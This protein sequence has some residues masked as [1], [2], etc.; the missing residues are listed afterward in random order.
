MQNQPS[1]H[2]RS[3]HRNSAW[4]LGLLLPLLLG[5]AFS[6]HVRAESMHALV[7]GN[8]AYH[9]GAL[10]NPANDARLMDKTL[11][12]L[13][14][15][16]TT[17]IDQT[18]Q[19]MD[20]EIAEF[21][22]RVP[23][24]GLAL[25]FFAGHGLQI[26]GENYLV[27]I[28]A[29][30]HD[31]AA[32][33]YKT[34]SQN[35]V[36]DS[37]DASASNMNVIVL[38]CCR[39]NPFERAWKRSIKGRGLAPISV[40][41]E[42]T[43]IA[44]ATA[45]GQ[46]ALDG[47]GT[48]S[49]YTAE[50]AK[51]FSE[52]PA[53]GLLLRDVFFTASAAVKKATGQRPWLNLDASLD[54]FYLRQP[55]NLASREEM[56]QAAIRLESMGTSSN[57]ESSGVPSPVVSANATS[58]P[59]GASS[60]GAMG[61][62][63]TNDNA[64]E[65]TSHAPQSQSLMRQANTWLYE[66]DYELAID[67]FSAL[68]S[69][70]SLS[71]DQRR[72]VRRSRGVAYLGRR[73]DRDIER[74][75]VDYKAAGSKGIHMS[76]IADEAALKVGTEVKATVRKNQIAL[77]TLSKGD[78]LWVEAVQDNSQIQ[79]WVQ[80]SVFTKSTAPSTPV[81]SSTQAVAADGTKPA[82]STGTSSVVSNTSSPVQSFSTQSFPVQSGTSGMPVTSSHGVVQSV[83]INGTSQF[84]SSSQFHQPQQFQSTQRVQ[85]SQFRQP[86]TQSSSRGFQSNL[87][88]NSNQGNSSRS[89][90]VPSGGDSFTKRYFQKN[91][92][93][94]SI[95]ETPRWESPSEIRRLRAQGLVR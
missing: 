36:I 44:Y 89:S 54:A 39:D 84:S 33:K 13:G 15:A 29:N 90:S 52:R 61:R 77:V 2:H 24:N 78:W 72:Q 60:P 79:G 11:R 57:F 64:I 27:P 87:F 47:A 88:S 70:S 31:A 3:D 65:S 51:A 30:I 83:P 35:F 95:W 81:V 56:E 9:N 91:G 66:G 74:A 26:N 43:L 34:V 76:V 48:N 73:S 19:Q 93:A 58:N 37:L 92:R 85:S 42:G 45:P 16:V 5:L 23:K 8:G 63:A 32:V 14:F 4:R 18:Q 1:N 71:E 20:Q 7:I 25:F 46:T 67:A 49:P 12:D 82:T 86:Q 59:I 6:D 21:C 68:I 17:R 28:D 80:K 50:L 41:P 10:S 22:R 40:I 75:I 55:N 94:P 53:S 69:D 38:D 62:D